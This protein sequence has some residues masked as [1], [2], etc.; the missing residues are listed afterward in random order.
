MRGVPREIQHVITSRLCVVPRIVYGTRIGRLVRAPIARVH[1][2]PYM[3][4][5]S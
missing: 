5:E 3:H 1:R 2:S 4:A